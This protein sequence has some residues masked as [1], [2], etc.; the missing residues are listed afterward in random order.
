MQE[1]RVYHLC[2]WSILVNADISGGAM[3]IDSFEERAP[4]SALL[5]AYDER[6]L[7][8]YLRLLDADADGADWREAAALIFNLD[9]AAEPDRAKAMHDSHLARARWMTEVGYS[10]LLG[11]ERP[12]TR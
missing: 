2:E 7:I 9:V 10:R 11:C 3:N 8:D 6:H 5:T 12:L 4:E 1:L